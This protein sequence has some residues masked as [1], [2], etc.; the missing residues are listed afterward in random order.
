[1]ENYLCTRRTLAAYAEKLVRDRDGELFSRVGNTQ[2]D[3]AVAEI[4][5]A[6][7]S[8]GK[9]SP[10]DAD[11]KVSDDFLTPLFA[12]FFARLGLPNL[13][14]KTNFHVLAPYL[15]TDEVDPEIKDKLDLIIETAGR[16][17]LRG[18]AGLSR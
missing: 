9:P 15:P 10:W 16:A 14:S 12:K 3:E 17:R 8:L 13:M 5:N 2:M 11:A 1:V 7:R 4:E 18:D 6:L